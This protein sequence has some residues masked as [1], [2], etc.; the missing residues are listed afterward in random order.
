MR[1]R[2][3]AAALL[4]AL[5]SGMWSA[6]AAGG[7]ED[8]LLSVGYLYQ[9]VAPRLLS[10]FRQQT[11]A[12]LQPV[13]E[14]LRGRLDAVRF[15]EPSAYDYAPQFTALDWGDGGSLT[16]PSFGC[17]L[18]LEG[19]ARLHITAGEV[20]DLSTGQV[21]PDGSMLQVRHRYFAAEESGAVVRMY[22]EAVSGMVDGYYQAQSQGVFAPR[23]QYLD[24]TEAHWAAQ[25][26]WRLTEAGVVNGVEPHVFSPGG[27]VTRGAF[28]TIL[29][30]LGGVNIDDWRYR[31]FSD[32]FNTDWYSPYVTWAAENGIVGG[33]GDGRFG[34]NDPITRE[35][36]AAV[37]Q[38]FSA[39]LEAE[40][41]VSAETVPAYT[42]E[43]SISDW[44]REAVAWAR[45]A[46]LMT[47]RDDGSFDPMG[48][49]NRAEICTVAC[50]LGEKA[51]LLPEPEETAE[52]TDI[53]P[54]PEQPV[55]AE[56]EPVETD[57]DTETK[58]ALEA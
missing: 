20:I 37:I 26:I 22:S 15:P 21:C 58:G 17:F 53:A 47:G 23:E 19:Q 28:V 34:P 43:A 8:P 9:T 14:D 25:A 31:H 30:R 42:D 4:L 46:G 11:D 3:L 40:L 13:A 48:T 41:S 39:Y 7:A 12:R 24:L 33:Y 38:R 32:V 57:T 29:G 27:T 10:L 18:L 52:K 51:G 36:M 1:R 55:M 44:A 35:Q 54:E 50:R 56:P 6:L 2:I 45:D 49:A 16:L 5:L